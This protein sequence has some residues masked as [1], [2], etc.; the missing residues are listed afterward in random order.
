V[1]AGGVVLRMP[2]RGSG[3]TV[4]SL[5]RRGGG[6]RGRPIASDR[7]E[8][9]LRLL[10]PSSARFVLSGYVAVGFVVF[11]AALLV[12][13]FWV[14][15]LAEMTPAGMSGCQDAGVVFGCWSC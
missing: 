11:A 10:Q 1:R 8:R 15:V 6:A 2:A 12:Y 14:V 4:Y 7:R 3:V 13:S 5:R 9:C